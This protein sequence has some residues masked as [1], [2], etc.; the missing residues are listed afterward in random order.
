MK[1]LMLLSVAAMHYLVFFL[2]SFYHFQQSSIARI[3]CLR[4]KEKR[5][6][7]RFMHGGFLIIHVLVSL[8]L[9]IS[10]LL[11]IVRYYLYKL[12]SLK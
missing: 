10:N 7:Q 12:M 11:L 8:I 1:L 6:M 5:S 4:Q 9:V 2:F 3:V